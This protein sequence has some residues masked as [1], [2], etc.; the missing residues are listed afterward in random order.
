MRMHNGL[1]SVVLVDVSEALPSSLI[2]SN[3]NA[4]RCQRPGCPDLTS[5]P[6]SEP[7]VMDHFPFGSLICFG[8][9]ILMWFLS[10]HCQN[11]QLSSIVPCSG[12]RPMPLAAERAI[13][14]TIMSNPMMRHRRRRNRLI[15]SS[16]HT[17]IFRVRR[18]PEK[19][20]C[21]LA[22]SGKANR[23]KSWRKSGTI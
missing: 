10:N 17:T 5:S 9:L 12:S 13:Q 4:I 20:L 23:A 3:V 19:V 15:S 14:T 2:P 21:D 8:F 6:C 1:K 7:A 22:V 11:S 16:R 18:W